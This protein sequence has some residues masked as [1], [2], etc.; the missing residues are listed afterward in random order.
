MSRILIF[1][2]GGLVGAGIVF[3]VVQQSGTSATPAHLPSASATRATSDPV[4]IPA[5]TDVT[6]TPPPPEP[7]AAPPVAVESLP[8]PATVVPITATEVAPDTAMQSLAP[9]SPTQPQPAAPAAA[10]AVPTGESLAPIPPGTLLVPVLGIKTEQL[11]DTYTQSRGAGRSHDAIDIMAPKGTP[12]VAVDDGKVVKLF[13]SARGGLTVYQFDR[14]EKFAYYYAHLDGYAPGV[15][16]GKVLKRGELVGYVG[17][18]GDA[19]PAAPHLHFAISVLG[20]EKSWWKGYPTNPFLPLGG[21]I[22]P[23]PVPSV[24]RSGSDK[25]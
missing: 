23:A 17:S 8:T 21:R 2:L 15:V 12:V 3:Y 16:E 22:R 5:P 24:R 9:P 10:A 7:V 25:R 20:P 18:T 4:P 13:T 11:T 14:K 1:V 6:P 19:N